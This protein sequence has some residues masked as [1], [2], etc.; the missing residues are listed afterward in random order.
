VKAVSYASLLANEEKINKAGR[1]CG[2]LLCNRV[3]TVPQN[4]T[5]MSCCFWLA[6]IEGSSDSVRGTKHETLGI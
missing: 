6:G 5:M 2:T 4:T 3:I 1:Q